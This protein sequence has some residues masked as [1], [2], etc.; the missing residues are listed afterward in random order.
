MDRKLGGLTLLLALGGCDYVP[1]V[2]QQ[3]DTEARVAAMEV[4]ISQLEATTAEL[5]E[6]QPVVVERP[7]APAPAP[8]SESGSWIMWQSQVSGPAGVAGAYRKP[9]PVLA[10]AE[11][12]PCERDI[13]GNVKRLGGEGAVY[14]DPTGYSFRLSCLPRGVEPR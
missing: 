10:Y 4:R 9:Q 7:A 8:R 11:Q 13:E 14:V 3:Q 12:P 2:A 1:S 6:R 5:A